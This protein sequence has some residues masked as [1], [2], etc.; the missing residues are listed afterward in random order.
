MNVE[1][2]ENFKLSGSFPFVKCCVDPETRERHYYL[3]FDEAYDNTPVEVKRGECYV[4]TV[5]EAETLGF[6][7]PALLPTP[8]GHAVH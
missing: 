6:R 1:V 5:K 2:K 7:R 8:A 3:P 4:R